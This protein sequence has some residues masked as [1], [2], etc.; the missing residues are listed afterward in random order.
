MSH[1]ALMAPNK[2]NNAAPQGAA[3]KS[4]D[5][6]KP[7]RM[8]R[9][10][11]IFAPGLEHLAALRGTSLPEEVNRAVRELLE[12]EKLWPPSEL[13]PPEEEPDA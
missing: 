12:R 1:T 5:R 13:C 4:T 8:V 6:H 11:E 3:K 9:V 2:K 7:S 10:K